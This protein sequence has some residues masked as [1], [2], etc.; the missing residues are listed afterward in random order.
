MKKAFIIILISILLLS[1][2]NKT[3]YVVE[4]IF[5]NFS[6]NSTLSNSSEI[7]I[8]VYDSTITHNRSGSLESLIPT[9]EFKIKK[10]Q[11]LE[12]FENI[13]A[14][15]EK[16]SYFCCPTSTYSI[17]FLNQKDTLDLFYVDTLE[18]K[19]KVRIFESS[20]Q[21]SYIIDKQ[22]WKD[23]LKEIEKGNQNDRN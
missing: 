19:D 9:K 6:F 17:H 15:A 2:S 18:F 22:K 4:N 20:Y 23:Y 3:Q 7:V 5:D 12:D 11:Q 8:K 1:C 21:Y 13:F 16:T 14:K 10:R